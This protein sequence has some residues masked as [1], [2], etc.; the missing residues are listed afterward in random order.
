MI[1][2]GTVGLIRA[3]AVQVRPG[4]AAFTER[5]VTFTDGSTAAFDAVILATGYRPA[6]AALL[7]ESTTMTDE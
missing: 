2:V 1:D 4:I 5:G 7:P 3:G 6:I